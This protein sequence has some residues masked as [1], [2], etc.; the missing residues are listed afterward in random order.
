MASWLQAP[1]GCC[2]DLPDRDSARWRSTL[3]AWLPRSPQVCRARFQGGHRGPDGDLGEADQRPADD[4]ARSCGR[5][6]REQL[7][8]L[9]RRPARQGVALRGFGARE[10]PVRP[11]AGV[12]PANVLTHAVPT[13]GWF[14]R[15][16]RSSGTGALATVPRTTFGTVSRVAGW[17]STSTSGQGCCWF[18]WGWGRRT[19]SRHRRSGAGPRSRCALILRRRLPS[20]PAAATAWC[21]RTFWA[22]EPSPPAPPRPADAGSPPRAAVPPAAP[23]R[24]AVGRRRSNY[25]PARWSAWTAGLAYALGGMLGRGRSV[26]MV[27]RCRSGRGVRS[28]RGAR[29]GWA[30]SLRTCCCPRWHCCDGRTLCR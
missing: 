30:V 24:P 8:S 15:R 19:R 2:R 6:G 4:G 1:S 9:S 23:D 7:A 27:R 3:T 13:R 28:A 18:G 14:G 22:S 16:P 5:C 11:A 20:W 25:G 12:L 17:S 29:G 21:S 10:R 26:T